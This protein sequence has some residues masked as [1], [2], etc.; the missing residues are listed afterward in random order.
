M[1]SIYEAVDAAVES[2]AS[3][4]QLE[5]Y[6][7]ASARNAICSAL[8]CWFDADAESLIIHGVEERIAWSPHS[9]QQL[10]A[11]SWM[12]DGG[13]DL[14]GVLS[15]SG[16]TVIVDWKTTSNKSFDR[17]WRERYQRSWQWRIYASLI[18]AQY[19]QYRGI[20][21][22]GSCDSFTIQVPPDN[23]QRV[24]RYLEDS[25][26]HIEQDWERE[27]PWPQVTSSCRAYGRDCPYVPYCHG[28]APMEK[29]QPPQ[30]RQITF[31]RLSLYWL[32]PERFR[33]NIMSAERGEETDEEKPEADFGTIVHAGL[34]AAYQHLRKPNHE[35][36]RHCERYAQP[37]L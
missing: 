23:H 25:I 7:I 6:V 10:A 26:R 32:C 3:A 18:N 33:M 34:A 11:P 4:L 13:L 14:W 19:F 27:G 20:H 22:S 5:P 29:R 21:H 31:S 35:T 16:E 37:T 36:K 9:Q 12:I 17:Q 15:D 8:D 2:T 30:F 1:S 24:Q 28:S